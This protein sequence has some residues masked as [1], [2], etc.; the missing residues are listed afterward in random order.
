MDFEACVEG[1]P[2]IVNLTNHCYFNLDGEL[3]V[4]SSSTYR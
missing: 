3:S 4:S 2:T 1:K